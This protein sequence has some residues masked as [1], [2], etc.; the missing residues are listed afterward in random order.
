[1]NTQ[2]YILRIHQDTNKIEQVANES[3]VDSVPLSCGGLKQGSSI[4]FFK[5]YSFV[6]SSHI[7]SMSKLRNPITVKETP[8]VSAGVELG[9][10]L[11]D[12]LGG[13]VLAQLGELLQ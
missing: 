9:E 13:E 4:D 8:V 10:P 11:L 6:Y 2:F 12:L 7:H 1:M 3:L 5:A